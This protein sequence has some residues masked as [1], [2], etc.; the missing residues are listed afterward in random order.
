MQENL[1]S[2]S[3]G[4]AKRVRGGKRTALSWEITRLSGL[5]FQALPNF[6]HAGMGCQ[7]LTREQRSCGHRVSPQGPA[8][9][10]RQQENHSLKFGKKS[11]RK[12]DPLSQF[13]RTEDEMSALRSNKNHC[14]CWFPQSSRSSPFV[15][16][17]DKRR[18]FPALCDLF[19]PEK[20]HSGAGRR[21]PWLS[22]LQINHCLSDTDRPSS[23][24]GRKEPWERT[25]VTFP[26]ISS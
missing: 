8:C 5:F 22:P 24:K 3:W 19:I 6:G 2:L 1:R 14:V 11:F 4:K 18:H 20:Q 23:E 9:P 16:A 10:R 17:R 7:Y 21:L 12:H 25:G 13:G 26:Y 15:P